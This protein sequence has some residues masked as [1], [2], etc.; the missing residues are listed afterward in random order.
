MPAPRQAPHRPVARAR[1]AASG[2]ARPSKASPHAI[3][4]AAPRPSTTR[5]P[6]NVNG[7][8]A[9]AHSTEP[10]A[11]TTAPATKTRRRPKSSPIAPAGRSATAKPRLI[12]LRIHDVATA[13]A[14]RPPATAG[15]IESG[16]VKTKRASRVAPLEATRTAPGRL[17]MRTP[18]CSVTE[19]FHRRLAR[20]V[21]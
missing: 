11:V 18:V 6:M 15:T 14:P 16:A 20:L 21:R 1:P 5:P 8:G 13:P 7:P 3:N 4:A 17:A 9:T 2:N 12:E 19:L 10:T